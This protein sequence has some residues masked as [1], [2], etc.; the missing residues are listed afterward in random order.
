MNSNR[1]SEADEKI[2]TKKNKSTTDSEQNLSFRLS[3]K[4]LRLLEKKYSS[5]LKEHSNAPHQS[6]HDH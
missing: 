2:S 1:P 4:N 3:A 5:D 6:K